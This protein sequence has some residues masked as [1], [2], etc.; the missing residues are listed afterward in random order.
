MEGVEVRSQQLN[1]KKKNKGK[2]YLL[3]SF[4]GLSCFKILQLTLRIEKVK[5]KQKWGG[6][7]VYIM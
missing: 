1:C 2:D 7:L 3:A 6:N 4:L 5:E